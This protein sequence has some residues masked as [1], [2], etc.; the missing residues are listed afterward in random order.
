MGIHERPDVGVGGLLHASL[1]EH[2]R[3]EAP[4]TEHPLHHRYTGPPR[5]VEDHRASRGEDSQGLV[6]RPGV[7]A[8]TEEIILLPARHE[9]V[10][11]VV[12]ALQ[13]LPGSDDLGNTA[14]IRSALYP[15]RRGSA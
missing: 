4:A 14:T 10:A 11:E 12:Q 9:V 3:L 5:Q 2:L 7:Q 13:I 1:P 15:R 6:E 8:Q